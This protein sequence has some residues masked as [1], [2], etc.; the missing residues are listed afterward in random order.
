MKNPVFQEMD[1]SIAE[2]DATETLPPADVDQTFELF[3]IFMG[4]VERTAL[5][6][7]LPREKIVE[8]STQFGW[9]EKI[10]VLVDMRLS[11]KPGDS[12]RGVN[13]AINFLQ[14]HRLRNVLQGVLKKLTTMSSSDLS[15]LLFATEV[16][17]KGIVTRK[18]VTRCFADLA[19][20]LEKTHSMTYQ[21][22]AD[23]VGDRKA[24]EDSDPTEH[25][26]TAEL[27]I[28]LTKAMA[29]ARTPTQ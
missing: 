15:D 17:R 21:A 20:A 26:T 12:E 14:A 10:K 3:C 19:S 23:T 7:G 4:D 1:K 8:Y 13:R 2:V 18:I 5:S 25:K 16:D 22:L 29:E 6:A 9:T 27:H 28:A 11:S 24:R